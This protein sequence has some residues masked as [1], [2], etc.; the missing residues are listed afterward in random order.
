MGPPFSLITAHEVGVLNEKRCKTAPRRGALFQIL[1]GTA[2]LE[3]ENVPFLIFNG[4]NSDSNL[5]SLYQHKDNALLS[6][7]NENHRG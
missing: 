4:V 6:L 5:L 7:Q 3:I 2:P 1:T